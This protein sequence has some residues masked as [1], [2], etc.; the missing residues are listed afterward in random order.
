MA[1][2]PKLSRNH[3]KHISSHSLP[4]PFLY[5][6][7]IKL[8]LTYNSSIIAN[9]SSSRQGNFTVAKI[10]GKRLWQNENAKCIGHFFV[11]QGNCL[12]SHKETSILGTS[13]DNQ[14][15]GEIWSS[16]K[17]SPGLVILT[18]VLNVLGS[19]SSVY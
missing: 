2:T 9:S 14:S 5:H 13:L 6:Y 11:R 3:Q 16:G 19:R 15:A 7:K 17:T 12:P 10:N 18:E 8:T 1:L 4:C